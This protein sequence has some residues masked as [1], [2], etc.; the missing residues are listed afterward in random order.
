MNLPDLH[1]L[2][3]FLRVDGAIHH[4]YSTYGRGPDAPP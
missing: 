4:T 3:C 1:G 2:S